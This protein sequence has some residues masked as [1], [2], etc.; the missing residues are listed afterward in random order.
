MPEEAGGPVVVARFR[1]LDEALVAQMHLGA[2]GIGADLFDENVV[3]MNWAYSQAVGGIRLVVAAEDAE[4]AREL[5]AGEPPAPAE[6]DASSLDTEPTTEATPPLSTES[7]CPA[8]GSS[9]TRREPNRRL[10]KGSI[11]MMILLPFALLD[12]LVPRRACSR[13]GHRWR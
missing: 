9:E 10:Q 11:L 3:R 7:S 12:R 4:A 2:A 5:L 1:D 6:E 13:C 8:C